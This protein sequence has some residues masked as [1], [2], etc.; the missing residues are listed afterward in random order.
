MTASLLYFNK[1]WNSI[2]YEG[3]E[4]NPYDTCVTNKIIKGGY[5]T[6]CSHVDDCKLSHKITK[7]V[8]N[9]ITWIDNEH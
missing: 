4:S 3:Y 2:E 1:F 8:L 6:V 5:M 7:V 9:N